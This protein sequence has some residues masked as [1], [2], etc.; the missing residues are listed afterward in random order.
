MA[1]GPIF[2]SY[3][4]SDSAGHAGRIYDRIATRFPGRV[5]RD[6]EALTPGVDFVLEID[7]RVSTASAMV[8]VIGPTWVS[9]R[10]FEN[11]DFVRLEVRAALQ[12]NIP[13]IPVL[14]L[15]AK[16]PK[17]EQLPP[18]LS[19]LVRRQALA[20]RED[21]FDAGMSKLIHALETALGERPPRPA[22]ARA[23]GSGAGGLGFAAG[24]VVASLGGILLCGGIGWAALSEIQRQLDKQQQEFLQANTTIVPPPTAPVPSPAAAS[25]A[26]APT[27]TPA[28]QVFRPVG[29]WNIKYPN[30]AYGSLFLFPDGTYRVDTQIGSAVGQWNYTEGNQMLALNGV[31]GSVS[32]AQVT[33]FH[34]VPT[35]HW[36]AVSPQFGNLEFW[37]M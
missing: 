6:F 32:L 33:E 11:D 21:A 30:G 34:G 20:V 2:L 25:A 12:R 18:D 13:T 15:D 24:A 9:E 19:A 8:V 26:P 27:G 22:G 10:L 1:R 36:H 4:R 29:T 35:G 23:T 5:F 31:D 37:P 28:S 14:V 7:K 17:P 16:L 3:R